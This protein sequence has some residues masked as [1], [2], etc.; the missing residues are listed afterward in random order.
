MDKKSKDIFSKAP[1]APGSHMHPAFL[2]ECTIEKLKIKKV[3]IFFIPSPRPIFNK[4]PKL[5][6]KLGKHNCNKYP[7]IETIAKNCIT[8][9]KFGINSS[10]LIRTT[11]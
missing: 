7:K 8:F 1:Y 10:L 9:K 3:A 11:K 6:K 4:F 5:N 2:K